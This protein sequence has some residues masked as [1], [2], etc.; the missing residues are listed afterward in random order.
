VSEVAITLELNGRTLPV[1]VGPQQR[2]IDVLRDTLGLTGTKEGCGEGECGA[3]TVLVDGRAVNSCL[4]LAAE[5]DG[6]RVTTVEGL[7]GPGG[8]LSAV[9]EAFLEGGGVQCGFCTPGMIMIAAAL[10][11]EHSDPTDAEIRDA[12]TGNLCRCTG[13]VQIVDSIRGAAR[14]R[15]GG[16][17]EGA[18]P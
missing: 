16:V 1:R 7:V 3:C 12:L 15:L 13:Y 11:E 4:F 18:G 14:R 6:C 17:A 8:S 2:L 9:Q 5:A 10:L